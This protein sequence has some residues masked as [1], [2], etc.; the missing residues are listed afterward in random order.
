MQTKN[1]DA[2]LCC[3]AETIPNLDLATVSVQHK[4]GVNVLQRY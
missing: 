1:A 2:S 4:V 3:L